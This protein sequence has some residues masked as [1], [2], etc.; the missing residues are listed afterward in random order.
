MLW[1]LTKSEH[2]QNESDSNSEA[3]YRGPPTPWVQKRLGF[4]RKNEENYKNV[5]VRRETLMQNSWTINLFKAS[6][7]VFEKK[8]N[9][10]LVVTHFGEKNFGYCNLISII[11]FSD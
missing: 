9:Q 10:F 3:L 8:K 5:R 2:I 6:A 4:S 1:R 11:W 7:F